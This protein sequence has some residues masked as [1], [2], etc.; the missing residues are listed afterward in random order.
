MAATGA[1]NE[2]ALQWT[3]TADLLSRIQPL[4]DSEGWESAYAEHLTFIASAEYVFMAGIW[5]PMMIKSP[6]SFQKKIGGLISRRQR[7]SEEVDWL[8]RI[9]HPLPAA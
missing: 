6:N 3:Q 2:S 7:S 9:R 8:L 1:E 5:K 4:P